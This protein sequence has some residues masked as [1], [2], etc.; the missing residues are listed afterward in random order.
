MCRYCKEAVYIK[1]KTKD[2]E[3]LWLPTNYCPMCGEKVDVG[4]KEHTDKDINS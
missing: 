4:L 2:G 1:S 3:Y